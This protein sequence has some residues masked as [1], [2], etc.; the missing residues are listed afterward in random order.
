[1]SHRRY[2]IAV[3]LAPAIGAAAMLLMP[4]R[5]AAALQAVV[6]GAGTTRAL[7]LFGATL[8]ALLCADYVGTLATGAYVA[9]GTAEA[10]RRAAS[11]ALTRSTPTGG[12]ADQ[13]TRILVDCRQPAALLPLLTAV[14]LAVINLV[15]AL[16]LLALIDWTLVL[17]IVVGLL[18]ITVLLRRLVDDLSELM[19]RYRRAQA[20]VGQ[21]LLDAQHGAV[22]IRAYG[23]WRR[24]V[25]R[26]LEAQP[27][28]R[29]A[30][31]SLWSAQGRFAWR[32][33]VVVP[34]LLLISVAVG[35]WS[36]SSGRIDMSG[37]VAA[38]A[39]TYLVISSL[40]GVEAAAGLGAVRAARARLAGIRRHAYRPERCPDPIVAAR[41]SAVGCHCR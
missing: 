33:A 5:L 22:T 40:D 16:T 37:Y 18:L 29:S 21:R 34:A 4:S 19:Q 6:A 12:T 24:E 20:G 30:G 8:L 3:V 11:S 13:V 38:I 36:L 17:G 32:S 28:V 26:V 31:E 9:L 15:A 2:P 1:M 23:T 35:G 14:S 10:R 41:G 27:E 25:A 7:V 39:Y